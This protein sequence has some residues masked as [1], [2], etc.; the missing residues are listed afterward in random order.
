MSSDEET[1]IF[2]N[3]NSD[4]K[5]WNENYRWIKKGWLEKKQWFQKGGTLKV[6]IL[7]V[8]KLKFVT[9]SQGQKGVYA[10]YNCQQFFSIFFVLKNI[11]LL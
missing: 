9:L 5:I 2:P 4:S 3:K 10:I 11:P 6:T 8:F 1:F 7:E